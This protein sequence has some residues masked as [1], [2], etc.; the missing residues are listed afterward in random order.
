MIAIIG[1]SGFSKS[2]LNQNMERIE[3]P[4]E[5]GKV[6]VFTVEIENKQLYF[7]PRHGLGH[8]YPPHLIPYKANIQA[9]KNLGIERIFATSAVGSLN[10]NLEPGRIVIP[11]QFIDFTKNRDH[12]FSKV[13]KV[14]HLDFTE[15]FCSEMAESVLKASSM[16]GLNVKSGATYVVTEGPRFETPAEINAYRILGGDLVGMTLVPECV[17]ARELGMCYLTISIVTNLA[18][19]IK[20]ERLTAVEVEEMMK[21]KQDEVLNLIYKAITL[22]PEKRK[23]H[24]SSAFEGAEI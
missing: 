17:L 18:A 14:Y 11:D 8:S 21:V 4:T 19:G 20:G 16:I 2:G 6:D 12:S 7:L 1:G 22:L 5:Y 15:P 24:C 3:V 13:G 9:L 10:E 23:C